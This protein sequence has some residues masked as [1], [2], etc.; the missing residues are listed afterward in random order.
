MKK[1]SE[2]MT[3]FWKRL[4]REAGSACK[5]FL[6]LAFLNYTLPPVITATQLSQIAKKNDTE[7]IIVPAHA[8]LQ[9]SFMNENAEFDLE[10]SLNQQFELTAREYLVL[11]NSLVW[12]YSNWKVN[13][14]VI[15]CQYF[16]QATYSVY[17]ELLR[18]DGRQDLEEKVRMAAGTPSHAQVGHIWLETLE[19][20]RILE[21]DKILE[22]DRILKEGKTAEESK[23]LNGNNEN[24]WIPFETLAY[25]PVLLPKEVIEY[26]DDNEEYHRQLEINAPT[27]FV[28]SP[29]RSF[30]YPHLSLKDW[31][32]I[33]G[34]YIAV[35]D[36]LQEGGAA[37][38]LYRGIRGPWEKE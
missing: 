13:P 34:S 9:N 30:F 12:Q 35:K 26:L 36:F 11:A 6:F 37:G 28:T 10:R 22:E 5:L 2:Q 25:T 23:T 32:D 27:E 19:E 33:S 16:S 1:D 38:I 4:K 20:G 8:Y 31:S 14:K 29:G 17:R 7:S 18:V 21:E 3:G 15:N 24:H